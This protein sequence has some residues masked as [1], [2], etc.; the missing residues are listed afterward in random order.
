MDR[1]RTASHAALRVAIGC[2]VVAPDAACAESET[3]D[4]Q[5]IKVQVTG[6]RI[7]RTDTETALPVQ[8]ITRQEILDAGIQTMQDLLERISANQSYGSWNE[9]KGIG[10]LLVGFTG[11][12]LRG[13]GSQRTLV[14]LNG[15]RLA[16]YALSG[17]QSVDL[18]GIPPSAI[19]R[20]EVLKDGASAVYGTDAIG[21][22]INF[23]L[24]KDY[25]G[26]EVNGNYFA[27]EH[28]GGDSWRASASAGWGDLARD[29]Y[30]VFVTADYY[31]QQSLKASER[32]FSK[33][34]Y[35]PW[36]GLDGTSG[37]SFPANIVQTNL[38][39]GE[40]YGFPGFR[41]PTIPFPVGATADSCI[42]PYSF[43]TDGP[44]RYQCRFDTA[45]VIDTIPE[46]EKAHLIARFTWQLGADHQF[47]AE[48]SYYQGKFTQRISPAPVIAGGDFT[49]QLPPTSP[50][51]PAAFVAGQPGGDPTQPVE[52]LYRTVELG[53][54]TD[55]ATTDQWNG[56]VGMQGTFRG[57]DYE[58]AG[59]YTSNRQV[60]ELVSG[61]FRSSLF[62][63]LLG[64]GVINPFGPNTPAVLQQMRDTQVTGPINDNRASNYGVDLRLANTVATLPAGPVAVAF[65]VEARRETLEQSNSEVL[66]SGDV[67]GGPGEVPSITSVSRRVWSLFGEVSVPITKAL[68]ATA[69]ARY[70]HYSDFGGTTNSKFTVRWQP[71]SNLLL[72]AAYGTGFR[73][74]TLSDLFLPQVDSFAFMDFLQDP[75][76]CPVTEAYSDCN[77]LFMPV[78]VGG[79]P[80]LRPETSDQF[81]AGIVFAPA[82]GLTIGLD[83]YRVKVRDV[84]GVLPIDTILN[85]HEQLGGQYIV[86]RPP[87]A[88]Y[89]DL[90]G[91]IDYVVQYPTNTG[92]LTTSGVDINLEWRGPATAAGQFSLVLNGTYVID[93]TYKGFESFKLPPGAGARGPDGAIARY[94]QYAQLGW[95]YGSWGV[96]LANNY[97]SGYSE[98]DLLTC[99]DDGCTG[100]R[101][102]G[103]WSV[104]DVQAR[105]SPTKNATFAVGVRNLFDRAPPVSNQ[106]EDFQTGYDPSYAD[107]RGR[108][109]YGTVQYKFL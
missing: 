27:T 63:P 68:E 12:S 28:G 11:A 108:M 3:P 67:G 109:F 91:P 64:S 95:T 40:V 98:P 45:S 52:L 20:V 21:G 87:D 93:F 38:A 88:Q 104:W 58:F 26:A 15:R 74:P 25:T 14:L 66:V 99:G 6:T 5:R 96:T 105:Y 39:T 69:A 1:G 106:F 89:P 85:N 80:A 35:L 42:P 19:E 82:T 59:N 41:N 30:N 102:V 13:L 24:R 100:T 86:R 103:T 56:V 107:P 62:R 78:R 23:I 17:G 60:D 90:P 10:S 72:R 49:T 48:G 16:P 77:G 32:E 18:S 8:T 71:A 50:W 92:D 53:P 34:S 29:K 33:T 43:P 83:Y 70:D 54:R 44:R 79:N 101:R 31:R 4:D 97:Q 75:V 61:F 57:W 9:A 37:N 73:A 7:A 81:N 46:T 94:R 47:F 36:L 65:G 84:I 76:R 22:V 55:R 51:Y 2:L